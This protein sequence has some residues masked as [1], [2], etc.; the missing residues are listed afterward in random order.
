[1]LEAKNDFG[2]AGAPSDG[3]S[4][5][6]HVQLVAQQLYL[7]GR[8]EYR[9]SI[10]ILLKIKCQKTFFRGALASFCIFANVAFTSTAYA[11][12]ALNLRLF[13]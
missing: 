10:R 7:P 1:M 2:C 8:K 12:M 3:W 9:E 6:I 5:R 4:V 11:N 13:R